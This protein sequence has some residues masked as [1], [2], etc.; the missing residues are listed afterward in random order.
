[1]K[2][3]MHGVVRSSRVDVV[4]AVLLALAIVVGTLLWMYHPVIPRSGLGWVLLFV[5]GIPTWFLLEWLGDRVLS[6]RVFA[7]TGRA[8]RIALAVSALILLM[9]IAMY[10][11]HLGQRAI[12]SS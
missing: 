4:V 10:I 5:I 7:R 8:V 2:R 3:F 12:A 1:M 9:A 6:A 11:I